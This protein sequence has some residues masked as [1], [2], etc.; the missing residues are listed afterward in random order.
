MNFIVSS[1]AMFGHLQAISRVINSKNSLPILDCFLIKL[2]DGTLSMTASDNDTVLSTSIETDQYEGEGCFAVSSKTLLDALK[3][4]P[5]QPLTFDINLDNLE[6]TVYYQNGKYSLV[7]QD[8]DEYPQ[9][10]VLGDNATQVTINSTV[11][12][13][14]VNRCTFAT[15]DDELRPVMNGVYFD[16]TAADITLVATDGQKLVR[17]KTSLAHG[18]ANASFILPKKPATLLKNLLPKEDGDVRIGFNDRNASFT[19]EDYQMTCRLIEGR[20]PNYN[21]VIPQRNPNCATIDRLTLLGA[22]KRV[23]VFS[24]QSVSL[25][26]LSLSMNA[27]KISAQDIDFSTAAEETVTCLYDGAQMSI[28]FKSSFLIDILNNISSQNV[29]MELADPSRAGVIVPEEQNENED[30][31]MLLMPMMLN[32]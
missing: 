8:A 9:T 7:G 21:S 11:L 5:E 2:T 12:L 29:I 24:S 26:K 20:Y 18:D 32:D 30:L 13:N 15:G 6:I 28:G 3:E 22:L 31:L 19:L 25:V 10:P 23:A 27:L 4:I 1:T 14:G 16:I 17:N